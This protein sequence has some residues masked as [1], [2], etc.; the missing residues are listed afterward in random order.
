MIEHRNLVN[1]A[2]LVRRLL[3]D[4]AGEGVS[5]YAGFSF[6]ASISEV[7]PACVAGATLVVVPAD[8]RLAPRELS[9]YYAQHAGARRVPADAVRRAVPADRRTTAS[10]RIVTLAGEKLRAYRPMPWTVVNGYGPTEYTVCTTAFVVDRAVR[11]HPDRQAG[12]EHADARARS[13]TAGCARSAS[14]ASCASRAPASRAATSDR[15]ELTAEKFVA[16]PFAPGA[17]MYRTGDLARWRPD[18]NLEYLGRIDTQVK[19]RGYRIELGEIEQTLLERARRARRDRGRRRRRRRR[20]AARGYVALRRCGDARSASRTMPARGARA[21]PARLHDPGVLHA[22]RR[23]AADAERQGRPARAAADRARRR[24]ARSCAPD[25]RRRARARRVCGRACSACRLDRHRRDREL[26]RARRPLAQGD[27]AGQ[28]DLSSELGVE[29]KVTDVFRHPTVRALARRIARRSPRHAGA[30]CDRAASPH[31]ESYAAS[32]VQARMFLL[33]QMEPASTAYNVRERVRGRARRDLRATS[34]ARSRTLVARHD[35]FRCAFYARRHRGAPSRRAEGRAARA[36]RSTP[37]EAERDA[38]RR[39]AGA[40]V[41]PRRPRRSRAPR[42]SPPRAATYLFFDM[43]HIVT[44]G[45][46]DG[47]CSLDELEA[48]RRRRAA[49]PARRAAGR[50]RR[51]HGVGARRARDGAR[52]RS[53]ATYWRGAFPDGVPRARPRHRLPAAAGRRCP[54]ARRVTRE[55]PAAIARGLRELARRARLSLHALML[56]AF[57]VFLARVARQ[58]DDRGRHAG[59]RPLAPR[60]A[61]RVRHVRE[62]ARARATRRSASSRS[63]SSPPTSRR[64]SLEALDNQAYPF[65]DLVELVGDG[66]HAGHTPLVDVMFAMQNADDRIGDAVARTATFA[67]IAVGNHTAKFDLSLVVDE[68]RRRACTSRSST[69]RACS[70]ARRSIATCAAST[71]CSPTRVARPDVPVE[72]L[73]IL[74]DDDRRLV[75]VEFNRTEVAYPDEVAAH[76]MF[77]QRRRARAGQARARRRRSQLHLRRGR[78]RREPARESRCARLGLARRGHRRD[79]DAAVVRADHRRARRAQGRRRVHAARP[80]LSARAARVHAARQRRARPDRRARTSRA[81]STGPARA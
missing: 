24:R 19:V 35:A 59:Q 56:A 4:P 69:A 76:A 20:D 64:R 73:S 72:R 14:R 49:R 9:A 30:R 81:T 58:D 3:R 32:S 62:H 68:P 75:H 74:A 48:A 46:V 16:H 53:S 28:R 79:P 23:A 55:L 11:Q 77:E 54:R 38:R 10:L 66:R 70:A 1:F 25:D 2:L 34:R 40:A 42:G 15:P 26:R 31:A 13:R 51:L 78:R 80:S 21:P 44:D 8:M 43:H 18:G 65:A 27:R 47:A 63:P 45:V 33:Q 17:R 52:S 57:D 29:L 60:H 71:R 22:A 41:R 39:R 12:V 37:R 50:A 67:P 36:P 6:D 5:K 7:F 61:A